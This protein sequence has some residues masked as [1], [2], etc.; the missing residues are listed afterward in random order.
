[1]KSYT[2]L[3]ICLN[4]ILLNEATSILA[5][6]PN[7]TTKE[8][9]NWFTKHCTFSNDFEYHYLKIAFDNFEDLLIQCKDRIQTKIN[10]VTL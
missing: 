4:Q 5:F 10:F 9:T 8:C 2:L 6:I 7:G 1:M 3:L